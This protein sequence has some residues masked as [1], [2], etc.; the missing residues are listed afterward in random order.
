VGLTVGSASPA[1]P[2]DVRGRRFRATPAQL[3]WGAVI[4][5]EIGFIAFVFLASLSNEK[6]SIDYT[7][8][9]QA[10]RRFLDTGSPY[11]P[12]Q[13]AGPYTIWQVPILYPPVAFI[14]FVPFLWLPPFLWWVLPVALLVFCVTRHRPPLWAWAATLACFC[15]LPSLGVYVFGNPGMWIVAFVAA[16]TVWA[17]PFALVLLKPTFAPIALLGANRR[18]WW[19]ALA[20]LVVVSLPFGRLWID[21]VVAV[22]NATDVSLAYN[23]PTI[24]LMIAPLIPWLADPRHP[25]HARVRRWRARRSASEA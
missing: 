6:F 4:L 7:W 11:W 22:R 13:L 17:W 2:A 10:S 8:H 21:W 23:V 18:S 25:I 1:S 9:M 3:V 20:V 5:F 15:W 14:L 19:V 24:P 12:Y 16:G